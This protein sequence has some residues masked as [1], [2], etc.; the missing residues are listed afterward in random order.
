[1]RSSRECEPAKILIL[2][3]E[4]AILGQGKLYN[5]FVYGTL[6]EF[7]DCEDIVAV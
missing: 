5:G 1:M 7:T 2:G 6:L 3:Q 4:D